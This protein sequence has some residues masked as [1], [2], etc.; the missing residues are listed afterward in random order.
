M[1]ERERGRE[2]ALERDK[3]GKEREAREKRSRQG[4]YE[5]VGFPSARTH[6]HAGRM[7]GVH[8]LPLCTHT[9]THARM[10]I[11]CRGAMFGKR[12]KE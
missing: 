6:T 9:H 5:R 8:S 10:N 7:H 4:E 11:L 2:R 1:R 12:R 3:R